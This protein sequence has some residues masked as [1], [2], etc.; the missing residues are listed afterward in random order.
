MK[1]WIAACAVVAAAACGAEVKAPV[2]DAGATADVAGHPEP[3]LDWDQLALGCAIMGSGEGTHVMCNHGH[4][5]SLH[6]ENLYERWLYL[7]AHGV[8]AP[9]DAQLMMVGKVPGSDAVLPEPLSPLLRARVGERV[10]LR[11]VSYGPLFHTFH[12]HGHLWLDGGKM[13]DTHTMG[14]AEVYD[15][16]EFFAGA[17]ATSADP[18]AGAGDWMY[19]CH[20]ETHMATGMW[21]I[22][23]VLAKDGT[24]QLGADGKFPFELP[25]LLGG[26][27]QTVDVYVAA[28]ETPLAVARAYAPVSK[29]LDTVERVARLY[30]PMPDEK[31]WTAAKQKDVAAIVGKNIQAWT[32]WVLALR[33]GSKVRVHLR[34]FMV[35]LPVS[36]HPHG[37]AYDNMNDGTMPQNIAQ[38]NGAGV[39]YEWTADTPGTWPLHDHSKTLENI[40]RGLF[41]AIVVKSPEEEKTIARDYVIFMHDFDMDWYMGADKPTGSGH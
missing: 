25:P 31:A 4:S 36:L 27:G 11:V 20:V 21:G 37:V 34:N 40:A 29:S 23:R 22:F 30:V 33:Q 38:P 5:L 8:A 41:A 1:H 35:D 28:V 17:G 2:A 26:P 24:E 13:T 15:A 6:N 19:H 9:N 39:L 12:V 16:A 32:P 10:R 18:R 3:Q 14:P 7:K